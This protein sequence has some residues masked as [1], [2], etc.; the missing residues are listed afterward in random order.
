[1]QN[2]H[3]PT[4]QQI[5]P[6]LERVAHGRDVR[7]VTVADRHDEMWTRVEVNLAEL[8]RLGLVDVARRAQNAEQGVPI[9]FEPWPLVRM[10][11]VSG[12]Q[13]VQSEL[14]RHSSELLLGRTAELDPRQSVAGLAGVVH[15]RRLGRFRRASPVPVD[16][17]IDDHRATLSP[18]SRARQG[19]TDASD[20]AVGGGIVH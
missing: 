6:R 10:H 5:G 2:R 3:G 4:P 9:A 19:L 15:V 14:V 12:G 1:V 13:H 8:H 17:A 20:E 16:R 18:G 7:R 11:S